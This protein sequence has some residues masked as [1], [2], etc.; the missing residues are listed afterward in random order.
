MKEFLEDVDEVEDEAD[1]MAE[2]DDL[3]DDQ[4]N[5]EDGGPE[6]ESEVDYEG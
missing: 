1:D 4:Y 5:P 3:Q 2:F 6:D